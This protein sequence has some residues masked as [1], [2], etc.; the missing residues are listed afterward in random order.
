[1]EIR[2]A[3]LTDLNACAQLDG[4]FSTEHV[5]QMQEGDSSGVT[6]GVIAVAFR[7]IRL[8]RAVRVPYPRSMDHLVDHWQADGCFLVAA[9]GEEV[10]GFVDARPVAWNSTAHI[11]N[12]IVERGS[13]RRGIGT[14]LLQSAAD[15]ARSRGLRRLLLEAQTKNVPA[16]EFY[17]INGARFC[18]FN[19]HYYPNRDVAVFFI[20]PS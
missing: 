3:D 9:E 19:D 10:L 4:S 18:G 6:A 13:R 8:P 14:L 16:I 1:M 17:Q 11:A 2:V 5:W 7:A 15:W 12:L 20:R